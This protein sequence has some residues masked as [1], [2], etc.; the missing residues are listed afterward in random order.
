[1]IEITTP[2]SAEDLASR[3]WRLF[4]PTEDFWDNPDAK[5]KDSTAIYNWCKDYSG[6][7]AF[8]KTSIWPLFY[9]EREEDWVMCKLRWE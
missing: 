1:M 9:F 5:M 8:H 3:E 6:L 2:I 7:G 4:D